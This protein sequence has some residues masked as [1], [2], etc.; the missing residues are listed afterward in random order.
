VD[1]L[2]FD[3]ASITGPA[4]SSCPD[5][6]WTVSEL[7]ARIGLAINS[8][9]PKAIR[10]VGEVS[11]FSDRTHWYFSLKD[12][13]AVISCVMFA[14]KARRIGFTPASGQQVVILGRI[15]FYAPGGR[16]SVQVDSIEPVG[17][18]P[19]ELALR[20]LIEEARALGWLDESRKR[21][22]PIFP[23][24]VAVVT[25]AAGAALR[26]V[27]DTM[28]RR[29]PA[30]GILTL[31]VRVQG[32]QAAPEIAQALRYLSAHAP[33]LD[34]DVIL[35]TRGG[36]S[37]EDLWAFNERIVAE[38]VVNCSVPV[39]AAIGHETDI[40]LAELVADLRAATP[41][42]A[43]MR[44]TPDA[45]A[46]RIQVLKIEQRLVN[47]LRNLLRARRQ[48]ILTLA[49]AVPSSFRAR[50]LQDRARTNDLIARLARRSPAVIQA[51]LRQRTAGVLR[52][53][54]TAVRAR[55]ERASIVPQHEALNRALR[56]S[57]RREFSRLEAVTRHLAALNP[58]AVLE[59]GYSV[60]M[61]SDGRIVRN[62]TDVKT[63]DA[64]Q[65]RVARGV[66][67]S[68]VWDTAPPPKPPPRRDSTEPGLFD[69][70]P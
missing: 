61:R 68:V 69:P 25:S 37:A 33:R 64:L 8:A 16:V 14:S 48:T 26:D 57:L 50:I 55:L 45:A 7:C 21:P 59:R 58:L 4:Q 17:A 11:N 13:D 30:V 19:R 63:G 49:R 62:P 10:V 31:D 28:R 56:N 54:T 70:Q 24:R 1:R 15:D 51:S 34:I 67:R 27:L 52:A 9:F 39:V 35:L 53:L 23:R 2:P 5:R 18:G 12:A 42:Q 22:L 20:R 66:I 3:P 47:D 60:T 46:L 38:A 43:A 41:T 44:V 36:G 40:T 65:T 32:E 6:P 29:C